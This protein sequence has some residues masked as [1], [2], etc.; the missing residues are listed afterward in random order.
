M[1]FVAH[2][3]FLLYFSRNY[4]ELLKLMSLKTGK[5]NPPPLILK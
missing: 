1:Q 5:F 2:L 3:Q 4:E